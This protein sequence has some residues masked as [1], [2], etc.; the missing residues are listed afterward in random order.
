MI[1][2]KRHIIPE[3]YQLTGRRYPTLELEMEKM[4]EKA[5]EDLFRLIQEA[6]QQVHRAKRTFRPFPGGPK[7]RL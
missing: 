1:D 5:Q 2:W 3:A 4:S 6:T 7:I